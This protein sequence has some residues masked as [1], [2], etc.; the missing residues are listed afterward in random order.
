VLGRL[1]RRGERELIGECLL[2]IQER[3]WRLPAEHVPAVLRRARADPRLDALARAVAGPLAEWLDAV[4]PDERP[5]TRPAVAPPAAALDVSARDPVD[6]IVDRF[7]TG[8]AGAHRAALRATVLAME[9]TDLMRLA[10]ALDAVEGP[11]LTA[12][13]R[14]ELADLARL[15]ADLVAACQPPPVRSHRRSS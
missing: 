4:L 6:A 5:V 13:L 12:G 14:R 11:P 1:L 15:R 9:P 8:R 7:L 2:R 3:G 10:D